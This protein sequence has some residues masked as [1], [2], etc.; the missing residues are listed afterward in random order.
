MYM[1]EYLGACAYVYVCIKIVDVIS[2]SSIL[3]M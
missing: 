1:Y 2:L 3:Y